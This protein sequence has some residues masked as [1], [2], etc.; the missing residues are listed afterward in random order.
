M[1]LRQAFLSEIVAKPEDD[2]ARLVFADWLEDNGDADRAEFIRDQIRLEGMPEWDPERFD[3]EERSLDLLSAHW[4]EW[5]AGLPEG[6]RQSE[7]TFRRGFVGEAKMRPEEFLD[8][9]DELV[10]A[11][12]LQ[13]VTLHGLGTRL[14]ELA[15]SPALMG[16]PEVV[17]QFGPPD[18]EDQEKPDVSPFFR[19]WRPRHLRHLGMRANYGWWGVPFPVEWPCY[20]GL[21][22]LDLDGLD[23]AD[24]EAASLLGRSGWGKLRR[25][26]LCGNQLGERS[27]LAATRHDQVSTLDL[28]I[29]QSTPRATRA[30]ISNPWHRLAAL[31]LGGLLAQEDELRAVA[32][33][34]WFPGLRSLTLVGPPENA[35]AALTAA[36]TGLRH[37]DVVRSWADG[38]GGFLV[39]DLVEE[40]TSLSLHESVPAR[41]LAGL[42]TPLH[43]AG[44]RSL[45]ASPRSDDWEGFSI[46]MLAGVI[47]SPHLARLTQL[48]LVVGELGPADAIRLAGLGGLSRL[49]ALDLWGCRLCAAG[50]RALAKSPHL[51][52]LRRLDLDARGDGP[53]LRA[54]LD[55]PWL[56]SL[57]ELRYRC[58]NVDDD[59]LR[60]LAGNPAVSR[61]RVLH[62]GPQPITRAGTEALAN[63]PHLGG[64][65]WLN[66]G[67]HGVGDAIYEPLR[68]RFGGRF[69]G[70]F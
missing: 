17:I 2:V 13:R 59:D 3:V 53:C 49:R 9:G 14:E 67:N 62:L 40:L 63:S 19:G 21:E 41:A 39:S 64:L 30:V 24:G 34:A 6:A 38:L 10:A 66:V 15:R 12:P 68:E 11:V 54:L 5:T 37:L 55:A 31:D 4:E 26:R 69:A 1:N 51:G 28:S 36:P 7:L 47:E 56:A 58:E 52:G 35:C 46:D 70:C 44:L 16:L 57:R 50:V 32:E 29:D 27:V 20:Q 60:A 25:L 45:S 65:L 18:P 22:S 43:L 23:M 61:L 42:A 48:R 8:R 33:S